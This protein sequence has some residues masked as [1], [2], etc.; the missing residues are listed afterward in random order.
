MPTGQQIVLTS[1]TYDCLTCEKKTNTVL[2]TQGTCTYNVLVSS[3]ELMYT[4]ARRQ[5]AIEVKHDRH[6]WRV[7]VRET[8]A[9]R[10]HVVSASNT[11]V[12]YQ[13]VITRTYHYSTVTCR[14]HVSL[15]SLVYSVY[16]CIQ[17]YP[18][19]KQ[20]MYLFL[21]I[22]LRDVTLG[23]SVVRFRFHKPPNRATHKNT[24]YRF[25][26]VIFKISKMHCDL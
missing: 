20:F 18:S 5:P 23:C 11:A 8:S 15:T 4:C 22:C 10:R 26:K 6:D 25:P 17:T 3:G 24:N 2:L 14:Q 12:Y 21:S 19:I 9:W 7:L 16:L 13:D 1:L